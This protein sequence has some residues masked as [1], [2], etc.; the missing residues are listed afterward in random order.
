METI[1][2][3]RGH[4]TICID[5]ECFYTD[6]GE[7]VSNTYKERS[8]GN[9]NK[10]SIKDGYEEYDACIGKLPHVMNAC[11]GHGCDERAYVQF[12]SGFVVSGIDAIKIIN[13][14]K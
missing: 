4:E 10:Y 6:T 13:K 8:C 2:Y 7:P 1:G 12:W 3:L 14:I 9:C 5:E 11:C